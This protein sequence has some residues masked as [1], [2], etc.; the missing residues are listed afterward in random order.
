V[1]L[2]VRGLGLS[3]VAQAMSTSDVEF[4]L[5][6]FR[7]DNAVDSS[8]RREM[9]AAIRYGIIEGYPDHTLRPAAALRRS[10]AAAV[11]YR[12]CTYRVS[13]KPMAIIRE[14]PDAESIDLIPFILKNRAVRH[15]SLT[16]GD[17]HHSAH[18]NYARSSRISTPLPHHP[19]E[20]T[21][22]A[23]RELQPGM[24][25]VEG[26]AVDRKGN[27]FD[28]VPTA[29]Y[30]FD[31]AISGTAAPASPDKGQQVTVEAWTQGGAD[32]VT[33]SCSGLPSTELSTSNPGRT[34]PQPRLNQH[35]TG[36]FEVPSEAA[37]GTH[38][39]KLRARFNIFGQ[40]VFRESTVT[41]QVKP[42]LQLHARIV[43]NP[44]HSLAVVTLEARTSPT[45]D[46]VEAQFLEHRLSLQTS[47]GGSTWS[48]ARQL[49]G[50]DPGSYPVVF[51]AWRQN[52]RKRTTV[53]LVVRGL[54]RSDVIY[55]LAD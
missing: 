2:L 42:L 15:Y 25:L 14:E 8:V 33:A 23:G 43:P 39:L 18:W 29:V 7:D 45:A 47:D 34:N 17:R 21:S 6:R 4:Y 37:E 9:A 13:V 12:S 19:W 35:W 54:E 49:E 1:A 51:T 31:P 26:S 52:E 50:V 53:T 48:T 5:E 30:I 46:S 32:A 27:Q 41:L 3:G 28:A 20:G 40:Q 38:E 24:Y 16:V 44:A 36:R 11:V 10:E 55:H 22:S